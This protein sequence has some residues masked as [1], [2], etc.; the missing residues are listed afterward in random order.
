MIIESYDTARRKLVV[1]CA[2]DELLKIPQ[3]IA[4]LILIAPEC[5]IERLSI[6]YTGELP[7]KISRMVETLIERNPW[8]SAEEAV[9]KTNDSD[10]GFVEAVTRTDSFLLLRENEA[11]LE[12]S[13]FTSA[14]VERAELASRIA[15]LLS[16]ILGFP[17][18]LAY[19]VRF[20]IYEILM[21]VL[22]HDSGEH[23]RSWIQVRIAR[24]DN[25]LSVTIFDKGGEFDP[26]R[27]REFELDKYVA[28]GRRRGLGLV[29]M[30]RMYESLNYE[31]KNGLNRIFFDRALTTDENLKKEDDVSSLQI[32]EFLTLQDGISRIEIAG[33]LDAKGALALEKLMEDLIDKEI[34]QVVLDLK[35]VSF[36]SSA[37]IG[38]LI[39]FTSTL[40]DEG[41]E[42]WLTHVSQ[43][44]LSVL[45]LL[46]LDDFFVIKESEEDIVSS[47]G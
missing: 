2:R 43:Q 24:K 33:D 8:V 3:Y 46:N 18:S 21:N 41:G 37:G 22:E 27:E 35:G 10:V 9:D 19:D 42:V 6:L 32:G 25:R 5:R 31:R 38:M 45:S 4:S 39:G 29:L 26:T 14:D 16:N 30:Q 40:R 17:G 28:E 47:R 36:I 11:G 34:C 20:G 23:K 15:Y 7:R 44:V 12:Y 13:M 1:A